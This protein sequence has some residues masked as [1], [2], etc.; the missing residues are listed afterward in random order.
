MHEDGE[1][2]GIAWRPGRQKRIQTGEALMNWV[3]YVDAVILVPKRSP[4]ISLPSA[5][6]RKKQS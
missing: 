3:W 2:D 4:S 5:R 1:E 6:P